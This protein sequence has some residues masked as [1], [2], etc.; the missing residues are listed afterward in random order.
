MKKSQSDEKLGSLDKYADARNNS[1]LTEI[2][3]RLG[4]DGQPIIDS[5]GLRPMIQQL[6]RLKRCM[7]QTDMAWFDIDKN[8]SVNIF[9]PR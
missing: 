9:L 8:I 6:G 2:T 5:R 3:A 1:D 7:R 4:K